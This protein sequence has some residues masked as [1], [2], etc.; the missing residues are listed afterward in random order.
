[1]VQ[2]L[3]S[4]W[5]CFRF[6]TICLAFGV[7]LAAATP[8]FAQG[9]NDKTSGMQA[10]FPILGGMCAAMVAALLAFLWRDLP[11]QRWQRAEFVRKAFQERYDSPGSKNASFLLYWADRHIPLFA[12]DEEENWVRVKDEEAARAILPYEVHPFAFQAPDFKEDKRRIAL[13]DSFVDLIWRLD[14]VRVAS[15]AANP[16]DVR[17]II[18]ELGELLSDHPNARRLAPP[19]RLLPKAFRLMLGWRRMHRLIQFFDT[20][21]YNIRVTQAD[22]AELK[23]RFPSLNWNV[24]GI[25]SLPTTVRRCPI[26]PTIRK[27]TANEAALEHSPPGK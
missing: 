6:R 2:Q 4:G 3:R 16:L 1:M 21:G 23:Q 17:E 26:H 15:R 10:A 13:N 25:A 8:T 5:H 24:P 18:G 27:A 7:W 19:D 22:I 9:T 20:Y 11:A 12:D 14:H